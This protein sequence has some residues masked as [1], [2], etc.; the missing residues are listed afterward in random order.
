MLKPI[1]SLTVQNGMLRENY[2]VDRDTGSGDIFLSNCLDVDGGGPTDMMHI[3]P[4][5][6]GPIATIFATLAENRTVM[7]EVRPLTGE[8]LA[9]QMRSLSHRIMPADALHLKLL[10]CVVGRMEVALNESVSV[11]RDMAVAPFVGRVGV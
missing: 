4:Q 1:V 8:P 11:A 9:D 10:A 3:A 6:L 2:T 7:P 5:A